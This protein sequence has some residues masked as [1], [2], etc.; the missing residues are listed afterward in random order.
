MKKALVILL[1]LLSVSR[2]FSQDFRGLTFGLLPHNALVE[3]G[4]ENGVFLLSH[5]YQL[6]DTLSLQKFGRYGQPEFGTRYSLAVK[7]KD[8]YV[9]P[10]ALAEPWSSDENFARYQGKYKPVSY[11]IESRQLAD[12]VSV[13]LYA[14]QFPPFQPL[15]VNDY[16]FVADS[17]SFGGDGFPLDRECGEKR[18]WCVWYTIPAPVERIDS[19][20]TVS[21]VTTQSNLKFTAGETFYEVT[22]PNMNDT[23][24]GG[25]YVVPCQSAIGVLTFKLAGIITKKDEQ[26]GVSTPFVDAPSEDELFPVEAGIMEVPAPVEDAGVQENQ[27]G[28]KNKRNHR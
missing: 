9:I 8:G 12:T 28:R 13:E 7:V 15:G 11:R 26:W 25:I 18:G 6:S 10:A 16:V 1:V 2:A 3:A 5:S 27:S 14:G 22:V 21:T 4:V 20:G 24:L 23:I 17:T 19:I